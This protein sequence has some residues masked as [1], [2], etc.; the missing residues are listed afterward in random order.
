MSSFAQESHAL[1]H[2]VHEA[3]AAGAPLQAAQPLYRLRPGQ[4]QMAEAV[5][6]AIGQRQVLAVEAGTGVGKTYAYLVPALLSGERVIISTATKALQDQLFARDLP[7][8]TEALGLPLRAARLKGRG[9]YICLERLALV[10]QGRAAAQ[11]PQVLRTV[12]EIERW[13]RVTTSGDLAELPRLDEASPAIPLVTSTKDSCTGSGCAHW[14]ACHVNRARQQALQ[15]DLVVINHHLLFADW[16]VKDSGVA[17]LLPSAGVIVIDEAHQLGDTGLQFAGTRLSSRRLLGFARDS[18]RLGSEFARGMADWLVLGAQMERALRQLRLA[19]GRP[20][21]SGRLAWQQRTPEGLEETAWLDALRG[22]GWALK[23][24]LQPLVALQESSPQLQQ[25]LSRGSELL[26][27]LAGFA[28]PAADDC[29][30][31][32]EVGS[33]HLRMLQSPLSIAHLMRSRMEQAGDTAWIFTSATLGNDSQLSWFTHGCGLEGARTLRVDSPFNYE[34]QAAL[35]VPEDFTAPGSAAHSLQ[36]ADLVWQAA[37]RLGGRTL[38]LTTTLKALQAIGARLRQQAGLFSDLEVLV[39]GQAP[40]LALIEGFTALAHGAN[41]S[42][43]GI[44]VASASFWEG[45]DL[46]GDTLQLVVIDKLPFP[47]PDDPLVRARSERLAALGGKAFEEFMLPEAALALKQ[48]A[49]R[50]IRSESDEGALVI[51]D[52][53][54]LSMS[55]GHKL[56]DS[57]PPMRWLGSQ[58][59]LLRRLEGLAAGRREKEATKAS[60]RTSSCP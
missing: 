16:E 22:L 24:I 5:A 26:R 37:Q 60:T 57:L 34:R 27:Q 20:T 19:A 52:S 31:W 17:E 36:V 30:R 9:A 38:V 3:F 48:G 50:L 11:D 39:Q 47:P 14:S 59:E 58:S 46:P 13:A 23:A 32:L 12:A 2:A 7:R 8:L 35:F 56:L 42:R 28:Q 49:G 41:G 6:Q 1:A 10:R 53:R 43:G 29:V 55:Y 51:C 40:K 33:R 54:L 45:V 25:L 44:L 21:D 4:L 15:A 18:L